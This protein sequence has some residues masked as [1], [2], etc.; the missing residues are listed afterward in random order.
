M[1]P[2]RFS[3][4]VNSD[5][6]FARST[7]E[8]LTSAIIIRCQSLPWCSHTQK[9]TCEGHFIMENEHFSLECKR[10]RKDRDSCISSTKLSFKVRRP[11]GTTMNVCWG[12]R[13]RR[14]RPFLLFLELIGA[15]FLLINSNLGS[16]VR[17]KT[18]AL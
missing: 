15:P 1:I 13:I 18:E 9:V 17:R 6:D 16:A 4:V 11:V 14:V 7:W 10:T 12:S 5:G 3:F 2:L 8:M